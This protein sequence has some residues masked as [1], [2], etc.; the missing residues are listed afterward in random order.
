MIETTWY[1]FLGC[2]EIREGRFVS[3]PSM[4]LDDASKKSLVR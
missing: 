2:C 1:M 3:N 4:R